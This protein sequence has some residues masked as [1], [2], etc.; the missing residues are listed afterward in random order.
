[1]TLAGATLDDV[2]ER[3]SW[4]ALGSFLSHLPKDSAFSR[5]VSP[6]TADWFGTEMVQTMLADLIDAVN[7]LKYEE[8]CAHTPRGKRKPRK[9]D[10]Y[11]RPWTRKRGR[12][13]G[14]DPIPISEFDE[15]W[16]GGEG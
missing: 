3:V 6:E 10:P 5:E 14:H 1:M 2:P 4:R 7:A 13:I 15:W 9:P 12:V 16:K 11:P 8:G